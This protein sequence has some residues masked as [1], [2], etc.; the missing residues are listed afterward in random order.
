MAGR[1]WP[2]PGWPEL[3][4]WTE[5]LVAEGLFRFLTDVFDGFEHEAARTYDD[6]GLL[7]HSEPQIGGSTIVLAERKPNWPY[8]PSLLHVWVDDA[9]ITL[10]RAGRWEALP[11]TATYSSLPPGFRLD[12]RYL[13][14]GGGG[15]IAFGGRTS[16]TSWRE[17]L[18][19]PDGVV[20]RGA[21]VCGTSEFG[22]TRV[23]VTDLPPDRRGRYAI[24][25]VMLTTRFDDGSTYDYV[26][27]TDSTDSK[28]VLA[29]RGRLHAKMRGSVPNTLV[30]QA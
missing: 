23:V 5:S 13:S 29:R 30:A 14:L 11:F 4:G 26:L 20:V 12:G 10:E 15:D 3:E 1:T 24:D 17:F 21:G 22:D 2:L 19:F 25:G 9:D 18:F 28:D 8:L 16:V 27:V 7:L 6:D